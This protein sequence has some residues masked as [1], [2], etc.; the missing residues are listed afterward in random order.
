[1]PKTAILKAS[2]SYP[3]MQVMYVHVMLLHASNSTIAVIILSYLVT[4]EEAPKQK[5]SSTMAIIDGREVT[6]FALAQ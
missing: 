2:Y 4:L 3:A 5:L 6:E 1:M